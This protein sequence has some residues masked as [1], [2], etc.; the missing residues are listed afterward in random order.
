VKAASLDQVAALAAEPLAFVCTLRPD[1]SPHQTPVWFVLTGKTWWIASAASN[2][3]VRN[4]TLDARISMAIPRPGAPVVAEGSA[5][6]VRSRW[7]IEIVHAFAA[8]YDGWDIT[9]DRQ[10]GPRVLIR[11][12]TA[13]WLIPPG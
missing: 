1:G 4:V 9:D 8:K 5:S 10:D 7:P 3:K 13:C 6:I 11:I 2:T 12:V